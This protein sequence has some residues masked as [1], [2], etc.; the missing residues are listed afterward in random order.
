MGPRAGVCWISWHQQL[1]AA[2]SR[3]RHSLQL[4][5]R[6]QPTHAAGVPSSECSRRQEGPR[7]L[8]VATAMAA[9]VAVGSSELRGSGHAGMVL[10]PQQ[11]ACNWRL[12][13][14]EIKLKRLGPQ[15]MRNLMERRGTAAHTRH[16]CHEHGQEHSTVLAPV[17]CGSQM[18]TKRKPILQLCEVPLHLI[19]HQ[20]TLDFF[21]MI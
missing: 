11:Q 5:Q 15:S 16:A 14:W 6:R 20:C 10:H 3:A 19:I 12:A 9:A 7:K 8:A 21:G 1:W 4:Q 18:S 17:T 13:R 2:S